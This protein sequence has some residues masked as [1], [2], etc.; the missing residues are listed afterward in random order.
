MK[1]GTKN[2]VIMTLSSVTAVMMMVMQ[3]LMVEAA[4]NERGYFAIGGE[5]FFFAVVLLMCATFGISAMIDNYKAKIEAEKN[6]K[7]K[8]NKALWKMACRKEKVA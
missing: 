6:S 3:P 2:K 5:W 7:L 1:R 8:F 4:Y